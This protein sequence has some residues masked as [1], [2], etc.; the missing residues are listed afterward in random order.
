MPT[1]KQRRQLEGCGF[2]D[3]LVQDVD[4]GA[5]WVTCET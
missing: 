5:Q 4:L 1:V 3:S 2:N